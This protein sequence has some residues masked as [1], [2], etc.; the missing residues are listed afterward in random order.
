MNREA[1]T[2]QIS[3]CEKKAFLSSELDGN[4]TARLDYGMILAVVDCRGNEMLASMDVQPASRVSTMGVFLPDREALR[5]GINWAA[6]NAPVVEEPAPRWKEGLS[7]P[8]DRFYSSFNSASPSNWTDVADLVNSRVDGA[9]SDSAKSLVLHMA[10]QDGLLESVPSDC[11]LKNYCMKIL[12]HGEGYTLQLHPLGKPGHTEAEASLAEGIGRRL[13]VTHITATAELS[14]CP[15]DYN[16]NVGQ[17]LPIL[18]LGEDNPLIERGQLCI[19]PTKPFEHEGLSIA[20]SIRVELRPAV[21]GLWAAY[22]L[23]DRVNPTLEL[24]GDKSFVFRQRPERC[25]PKRV[26]LEVSLYNPKG[27][28]LRSIGDQQRLESA[29]ENISAALESKVTVSAGTATAIPVD[30]STAQTAP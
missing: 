22:S 14:W 30:A 17:T 4:V 7:T 5:A 6:Q 9:N 24:D 26:F 1:V 25:D 21:S 3:I 13:A 18:G 10:E 2:K 15:F 27:G 16:F 29:M 8:A 11:R 19:A 23:F 28:F 12:W 20:A